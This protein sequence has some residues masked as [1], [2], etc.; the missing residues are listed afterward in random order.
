[1]VDDEIEFRD[2]KE[3]LQGQV[4]QIFSRF[5]YPESH[6]SKKSRDSYCIKPNMRQFFSG[7]RHYLV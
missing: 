2:K 6:T 3:T 7:R 5:C 4:K 1:M